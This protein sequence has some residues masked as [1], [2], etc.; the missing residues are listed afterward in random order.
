MLDANSPIAP[1]LQH[2]ISNEASD[3]YLTVGAPPCLRLSDRIQPIGES[4]LTAEDIQHYIDTLLDDE[5]KKEFDQEL[6]LNMSLNWEQNGRFRANFFWQQQRPGI[7]IRRIHT[8]IPTVEELHLPDAYQKLIMFRRGLSIIVGMTGS[9]KSTSL[10]AMLG[11]RNH[12]GSGHIITIEDPIEYVHPHRHCIF[13]QREIGIDTNSYANALKN[14]LRQRP[15]VVL[16]GEIRDYEVMEQSLNFAESGHLVVATLHANSANQAIERII[17]FFPEEKRAQVRKQLAANLRGI[18]AQ[19]LLP[20][21]QNGR[22][23]AIEILLNEGSISQLIEE[24]KIKDI[25]EIMAKS[26]GQGMQTFDQC[27]YDLYT[28]GHI[29]EEIALAEADNPTNL[30]LQFKQYHTTDEG[31]AQRGHLNVGMSG[32]QS[33]G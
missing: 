8:K 3:L 14:A 24:G 9:G 22:S 10:A 19:R 30:S 17:S 7:V 15:D 25:K 16:V 23:L 33:T 27:L 26:R 28:A 12:H 2:M 13:T 11:Y 32:F 5:K 4:A 20:N 1:L 31:Q 18:I 6:E 21:R 29:S